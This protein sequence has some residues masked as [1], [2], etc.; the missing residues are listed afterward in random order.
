MTAF[1]DLGREVSVERVATP[2]AVRWQGAP[3]SSSELGVTVF[4]RDLDMN[5]RR[6]SYSSITN[7]VHEQPAIASEPE[8][9]AEL[10]LDEETPGAPRRA[11]AG[12]VPAKDEDA[13]EASSRAVS[14]GLA[15]MPGG[16]LVGTLMHGVFERVAFDA[17]DLVAEVDAA[18]RQ[19]QTY[20]NVD[21][22]DHGD[23]VRGLCR[24]IESPLGPAAGLR[25][26]DV[27]PEGP[28]RRARVRASPGR[29]RRC[30]GATGR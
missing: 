19:E 22:G 5:W 16:T 28:S 18:L 13:D 4:D 17:D 23:V 25:L 3:E 2:P 27:G 26:R 15:A 20:Y 1:T 7:A 14:L 29:W 12:A 24:A 6:A 9:E 10:T 8:G 21:L 30:G 11:F